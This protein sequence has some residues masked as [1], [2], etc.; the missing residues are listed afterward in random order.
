MSLFEL[1]AFKNVP[2]V[3]ESNAIDFYQKQSG[4]DFPEFILFDRIQEKALLD[5]ILL[6]ENS[7]FGLDFKKEIN[8][9]KSYIGE[10]K[11]NPTIELCNLSYEEMI[12]V[13][14]LL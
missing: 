10:K 13:N 9:I 7:D 2:T 4:L 6:V 8:F 11:I 14:M 5:V 12:A 3:W 1:D